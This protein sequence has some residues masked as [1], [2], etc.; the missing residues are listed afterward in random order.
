MGLNGL[1]QQVGHV[2]VGLLV[3][4][5]NFGF[6]LR[7]FDAGR[8]GLDFLF[9]FFDFVVLGELISG[10]FKFGQ[11]IFG[12]RELRLHRLGR[13]GV[14][15][16]FDFLETRNALDAFAHFIVGLGPLA[17]LLHEMT[18]QSIGQLVAGL[19]GPVPE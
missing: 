8:G 5:A 17:L 18:G 1:L 3:E 14:H 15:R 12:R 9:V 16:V 2:R 4:G 19:A 7:F 13:L 11:F 10:C 6:P